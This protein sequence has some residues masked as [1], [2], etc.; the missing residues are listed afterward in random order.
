M[1]LPDKSNIANYGGSRT[2][3]T[4]K[5]NPR[6]DVGAEDVN[7]LINDVGMLSVLGWRVWYAFS[8]TGTVIA[9]TGNDE[10]WNGT[11]GYVAPLGARTSAGIYTITY[12]TT[13]LDFIGSTD[14]SG[15]IVHTLSLRAAQA[16]DRN[17]GTTSYSVSAIPTSGNIITVYLRTGGAL[18]DVNN[19]VLD[20]W[21]M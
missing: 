13:V 6:T 3:G 14:P 7:P 12:P 2:N 15:G 21:G 11:S 1:S 16:H 4:A 9:V 20:V 17:S 10:M 18:V 5:V 8:W 19:L